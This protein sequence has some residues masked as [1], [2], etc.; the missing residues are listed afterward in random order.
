[1]AN[2]RLESLGRPALFYI[3]E[4]KLDEN[5]D[6][7][8]KI[9]NFLT[10]RFGGYTNPTGDVKGYWKEGHQI[11]RDRS[12]QYRVAFVGKERIPELAGF[13]SDLAIEMKEKCIYLE[14][15]EDAQLVWPNE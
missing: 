14:T 3:P 4:E 12:R 13:L 1:M 8:R 7:Q 9:H 2:Y 5:P 15:G 6:I 10:D 11:I